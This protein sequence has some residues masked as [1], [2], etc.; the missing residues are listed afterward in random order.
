[1]M[2]LLCPLCNDPITGAGEADLSK[3][4]QNHFLRKH[5]LSVASVPKG[6]NIQPEDNSQR[7]YDQ[8]AI[9]EFHDSRSEK[10]PG[11]A[12]PESVICPICGDAVRGLTDDKLS[13]NLAYHMDVVHG[14]K[15]KFSGKS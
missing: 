12:L 6:S 5:N 9:I 14:M 11:E 13:Y 4:L 10:L 1:M 15:V 2:T 3:N 8:E 7:P